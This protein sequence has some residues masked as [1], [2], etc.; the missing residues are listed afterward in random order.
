MKKVMVIATLCFAVLLTGCS[1][2]I[3]EAEQAEEERTW[4]T[5]PVV[6][7]AED[8]FAVDDANSAP[9]ENRYYFNK[10][11]EQQ[12]TQYRV[13]YTA[14]M[15]HSDLA[16]YAGDY[17]DS[18]QTVARALLLD[19]PE[20]FYA[21]T[22]GQYESDGSSTNYRIS[23]LRDANQMYEWRPVIEQQIEQALD[24]VAAQAGL[25]PASINATRTLA[26]SVIG[27]PAALDGY[28]ARQVAWGLN[29]YLAGHISYD[30]DAA[31]VSDDEFYANYF[32]SNTVYGALVNGVAMCGGY[33]QAYAYLC[34]QLGIPCVYVE[35]DVH[36]PDF[37]GAHAWDMVQVDGAW[38]NVDP[39]WS[40]DEQGIGLRDDY[41]L[42]SDAIH[43]EYVTELYVPFEIP[44]A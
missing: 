29:E 40:D 43:N 20:I 22:G 35:G 33:A 37:E 34:Y 26:G 6:Q 4:D 18:M 24:A 19:C 32:D 30:W 23:Y 28:T 17:E 12:Q 39:T 7:T 42:T 38:G 13:L 44:S 9:F 31:E 16:N 11:H 2:V 1:N 36:A 41:F 21:A 5:A 10:L 14:L 25:D 8:D 3:P 15:T 27:A